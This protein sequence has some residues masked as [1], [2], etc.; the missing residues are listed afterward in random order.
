MLRYHR[1]RLYNVRAIHRRRYLLQTTAL[2]LFLVDERS[3]LLHFFGYSEATRVL[4][5]ILSITGGTRQLVP[6]L[7]LA[8]NSSQ[9][10]SQY[11]LGSRSEQRAS[12][13]RFTDGSFG[14]W[15]RRWRHWEMSNFEYL[16]RLNTAAGRTYN[17]LSQYPIMPWIL[18][19]YKSKKLNLRDPSVYRDLSKPVGALNPQRLQR[20]VRRMRGLGEG[21]NV[22]QLYIISRESHTSQKIHVTHSLTRKHINQTHNNNNNEHTHR[23][24]RFFTVLT[25]PHSVF[26]YTF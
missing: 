8:R 3:F 1:W 24:H 19:D 13:L 22:R 25:T 23:Y 10:L 18:C 11:E 16:M 26:P 5:K 9:V 14:D 4:E 6:H 2:E 7:S 17:D 15:T 12:L 20:L 21:G